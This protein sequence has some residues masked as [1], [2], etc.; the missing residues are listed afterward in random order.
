MKILTRGIIAILLVSVFALAQSGI[1]VSAGK[2][3]PSNVVINLVNPTLHKYA[4]DTG[5]TK[6]QSLLVSGSWS[7]GQVDSIEIWVGEDTATKAGDATMTPGTSGTFS[8][9]YDTNR[10]S[11]SYEIN[12]ILEVKAF[13]GTKQVG[14]AKRVFAVYANGFPIGSN[15]VVIDPGHGVIGNV[16]RLEDDYTQELAY[17]LAEILSASPYSYNVVVTHKFEEYAGTTDGTED[18]E[19]YRRPHIATESAVYRNVGC[20][21]SLHFNAPAAAAGVAAPDP[22]YEVY[23]AKYTGWINDSWNLGWAIWNTPEYQAILDELG[24]KKLNPGVQ[25]DIDFT[26][27]HL[28]VLTHQEVC[29]AVLHEIFGLSSSTQNWLGDPHNPNDDTNVIRLANALAIGIDTFM[30]QR[31]WS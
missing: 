27:S 7:G 3:P 6:G 1:T 17:R 11:A 20:F 10:L 26:T 8:Y 5:I 15:I 18:D 25:S 4:G 13:S 29:P 22:N 21:V 19:L 31:P 30:D 14:S 23:Q 2:P 16:R 12:T 9:T 28:A 24:A